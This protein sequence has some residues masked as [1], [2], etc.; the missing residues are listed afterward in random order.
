MSLWS[1]KGA[2]SKFKLGSKFFEL[3]WHELSLHRKAFIILFKYYVKGHWAH[4]WRPWCSWMSLLPTMISWMILFLENSTF[5]PW[6]FVRICEWKS[7]IENS[8]I[9]LHGCSYVE[10]GWI[11]T[12]KKNIVNELHCM[13]ETKYIWYFLELY[14]ILKFHEF[15]WMDFYSIKK[16]LIPQHS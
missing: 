9:R 2:L 6:T 13:D 5:Q 15:S 4:Y 12:P 16:G 11:N 1:L 14:F 7:S 3:D 10:F 8:Q